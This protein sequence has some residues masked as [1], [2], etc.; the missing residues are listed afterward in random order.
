MSL[1]D[2]RT[3]TSSSL[4]FLVY[5]PVPFFCYCP[6]PS[7]FTFLAPS[8]SLTLA[9]PITRSQTRNN[10]VPQILLPLFD[11]ANSVDVTKIPKLNGANYCDWRSLLK[12]ILVLKDLWGPLF[13][14]A[15]ADPANLAT[16][17]RN[18]AYALAI[19]RLSCEPEVLSMITDTETGRLAWDTLAATYASTNTTNVMR[20]E[21]A[22]GIARK[23]NDQ[24]MS[25]WI[26]YMKSL[27]SQLRGVGV[28]IDPNKVANRILN[29]LD[30]VHD[31]MKYALQARSGNLTVEIVTEHLLAWE[32]QNQSIAI[33]STLA[34]PNQPNQPNPQSYRITPMAAQNNTHRGPMATAL[35][36]TNTSTNPSPVPACC[37]NCCDHSHHTGAIRSQ[38]NPQSQ[39]SSSRFSP[40]PTPLL[41]HACGKYGNMDILTAVVGLVSHISAHH[42]FL[43]LTPILTMLP[44]Q[45]PFP[46]T[47]FH[48][49]LLF[50]PQ[51]LLSLPP[52]FL[53]IVIPL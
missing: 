26:A 12:D 38:S 16:W 25:Q 45:F 10:S 36:T 34:S 39:S 23:S 42:G 53:Q 7:T 35:T 3:T 8:S 40:Y 17:N 5:E 18:Q 30:A 9:P 4:A 43:L 48:Q 41:C 52:I 15:P 37:C 46:I 6:P 22:F 50:L 20:L 31:P 11:M 32:C 19:I 33:P 2:R 24:S 21:E 1:V 13:A 29:G 44:V 27:V 49:G 28:T 14:A 47:V 51:L